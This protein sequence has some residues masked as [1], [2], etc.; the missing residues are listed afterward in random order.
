MLN[1]ALISRADW[2]QQGFSLEEV[3]VLVWS[4]PGC[5]LQEEVLD[6]RELQSIF[7]SY[8]NKD[9]IFLGHFSCMWVMAIDWPVKNM[10]FFTPR[11]SQVECGTLEWAIPIW[12][13]A[14][15]TRY[16]CTQTKPELHQPGVTLQ[17][18]QKAKRCPEI[19]SQVAG[20][21]PKDGKVTP[22]NQKPNGISTKCD[23]PVPLDLWPGKVSAS[24]LFSFDIVSR[25]S[26]W[27]S[28]KK[29]LYHFLF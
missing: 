8:V 14:V 13:Q 17:M 18:K 19:K 22:R 26:C 20:V 27:F 24:S 12:I 9:L 5:W 15:C 29:L 10:F 21:P 1:L 4:A 11:G 2:S 7:L 3:R 16:L 23:F 6:I 25:I 28:A